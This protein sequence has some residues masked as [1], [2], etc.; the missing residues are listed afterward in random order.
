MKLNVAKQLINR[1]IKRMLTEGAKPPKTKLEQK[2]NVLVKEEFEDLV[3]EAEGNRTNIDEKLE[4]MRKQLIRDNL[5]T[6]NE[7]GSGKNNVRSRIERRV[8]L[9]TVSKVVDIPVNELILHFLNGERVH[10]GCTHNV[11]YGGGNVYFYG[12]NEEETTIK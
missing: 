3:K 10:E 4:T 2:F 5:L 1:E 9:E 11:K 6:I 8:P 7:R 12:E